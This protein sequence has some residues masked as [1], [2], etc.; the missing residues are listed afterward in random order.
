MVAQVLCAFLLA[1]GFTSAQ[2]EESI[3]H[4]VSETY[5]VL[6]DERSNT[7]MYEQM[8]QEVP[9]VDGG[10]AMFQGDMLMTE[11]DLQ[12]MYALAPARSITWP[13][14]IVPYKISDSSQ[15]D[16]AL[17]R[18]AVAHWMNNS[19]LMFK[20]LQQDDTTTDFILF[21]KA[22]GCWSRFGHVGSLQHISI[23]DGCETLA[24]VVHEI[25]HAVG[26]LHEQ[27]RADRNR[28][29]VVNYGNILEGLRS[30]F[31]PDQA[32]RD[33]GARYDYQSVMHYSPTAFAASPEMKTLSPVNPLLT[34]LIRRKDG[35]TF[36]DRKKANFL[37]ECDAACT[38]KP[39]CQNEGF[40]DNTC[41]CVCPPNTSGEKCETIRKTYYPR[42]TCGGRVIRERR[43][44]SPGYPNA[45]M[46]NQGVCVW[47][48][49]AP[50]GMK[51]QLTFQ[52]FDLY[53]RI[54]KFCIYDR[55]ELRLQSLYT[56][57]TYCGSEIKPGNTVTSVSRDLVIEYRP[58]AAFKRGF[59]TDVT[60]VPV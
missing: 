49:Q 50:R 13:G 18:R 14:G 41:K 56:G 58:Y 2:Y 40:V 36:R 7:Q 54:R 39:N 55:L 1:L 34:P 60:F 9:K 48:I 38:N 24:T 33:Y 31:D 53:D 22:R 44:Q 16:A 28:F 6:K 25:G 51:V 45:Q 52:G 29:V 15:G 4:L 47:W 8:L 35:L 21:V 3:E 59:T 19:C 42:P 32:K 5:D 20:E 37:Y 17:I 27:S 23:G 43:I 10:Q 46:P 11:R 30:Q 57:Q 26:F 12:E